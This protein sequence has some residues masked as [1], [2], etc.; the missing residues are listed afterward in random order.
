M[1]WIILFSISLIINILLLWGLKNLFKKQDIYEENYID[2]KIK[3][4]ILYR[5]LKDID[6]RGI[7]EKDDDV[8]STFEG[9]KS[10]IEKYNDEI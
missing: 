7:F 3:L 8:G 10:L 5:E 1:I 4:E 9:I 6:D 2:T